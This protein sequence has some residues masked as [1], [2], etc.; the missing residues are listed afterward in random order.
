MEWKVGVFRDATSF[1]LQTW[2][3]GYIWDVF[4]LVIYI[5]QG[6]DHGESQQ[7]IIRGDIRCY[8][9]DF[10]NAYIYTQSVKSIWKSAK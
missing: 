3:R 8:V 7:N 1:V 4:V 9:P 2:Q 5:S 6:Q 10:H